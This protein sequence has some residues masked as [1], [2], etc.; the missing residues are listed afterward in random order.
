MEALQEIKI[1]V[2]QDTVAE[3]TC[4]FFLGRYV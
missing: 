2:T 3:V 4:L 1:G